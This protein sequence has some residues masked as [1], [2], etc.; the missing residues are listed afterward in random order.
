MSAFGLHKRGRFYWT[1]FRVRGQRVYKSTKC[2]DPEAAE[3]VA[4]KW[5]N[6]L[7]KESE[8]IWV[9][10]GETVQD[11]WDMW[12]RDTT[13]TLSEA[14]RDR[15]ER[16]WRLHILPKFGKRP[17]ADI[18]NADVEELRRE[19]MAGTS[20]RQAH[21][22]EKRLANLA[23]KKLKEKL[24]K[25]AVLPA[26]RPRSLSSSNK[27]LLHFHLVFSWAQEEHKVF[28]GPL[29]FAVKVL[30]TQE[31]PKDSMEQEQIRA[32]L[33]VVD[34]SKS[35]HARIAIRAM[36]YWSLREDEALV[37]K[38]K[39]FGPGLRTFQHGDR[40]AKDAP[41]FP[42]PE[43][44]RRLLDPL[45]RHPS[46]LVLPDPN[47]NPHDAQFTRSLIARAGKAI[48]LHL[49]PHSMRHSWATMTAQKTQNAYVVRNGLGHKTLD[50]SLKY[51]KLSTK[52]LAEAGAAVF[53]DLFTGEKPKS[54]HRIGK[55]SVKLKNKQVK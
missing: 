37:M 4:A 45:P 28:Q 35:L 25:D 48:G 5:Y 26:Q 38:W 15:V 21:Q 54:H 27:L 41:R 33:A 1:E 12:W 53:G 24:P 32:Y 34:R 43:D 55:Y 51:V 52:D 42:V 29:P 3:V 40:K 19:Y 13:F 11:L 46:G 7:A 30:E 39:W 9:D 6:D 36:L 44:L 49:T 14:H 50:M 31:V 20:L 8:G 16:D 2:T 47:G 17:A 23:K 22:E 18:T 10:H